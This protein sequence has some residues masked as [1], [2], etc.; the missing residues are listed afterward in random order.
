MKL[1]KT[2]AVQRHGFTGTAAL[3]SGIG[4]YSGLEIGMS[5]GSAPGVDRQRTSEPVI[6]FS[7]HIV[8]H[9]S[10]EARN[11][12]FSAGWKPLPDILARMDQNRPKAVKTAPIQS[13][14]PI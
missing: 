1:C 7:F 12:P 14:Q 2:W 8:S 10:F 9:I 6:S 11:S 13:K 4:R 5:R 3:W